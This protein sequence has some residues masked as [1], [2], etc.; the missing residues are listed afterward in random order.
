MYFFVIIQIKVDPFRFN[1]LAD[2][3][4]VRDGCKLFY[5]T[6]YEYIPVVHA[7]QREEKNADKGPN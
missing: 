6:F 1:V 7:V 2:V 3:Y 5:D 4:I